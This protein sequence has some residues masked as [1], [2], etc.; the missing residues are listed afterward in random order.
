MKK[1]KELI[2][3]I[4]RSILKMDQKMPKLKWLL[5]GILILIIILP[6][7]MN[8]LSQK[9]ETISYLEGFYEY[10]KAKPIPIRQNE[11]YYYLNPKTG[12]K[13]NDETYQS[14][15]EYEG[16][17]AVV[18]QDDQTFIIN[19]KGDNVK[20]LSLSDTVTFYPIYELV[21]INDTLYDN[22]FKQLTSDEEKI[23]YQ[24]NGYST[25]RNE[26][27]MELGIINWEGEEIYKTDYDTED[28]TIS[29]EIPDVLSI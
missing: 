1:I 3:R 25:Y 17:F 6:I 22:D 5:L 12:K 13:V 28:A 21:Q 29:L 14:A 27:T 11:S 2:R 8:L 7:A 23:T 10:D 15:S 18:T 24:K 4:G 9:Q 16:E 26:I 19:R 20:D